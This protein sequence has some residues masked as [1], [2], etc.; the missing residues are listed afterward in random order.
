M[1]SGQRTGPGEQLCQRCMYFVCVVAT[2]VVNRVVRPVWSVD[3][4]D[5][6]GQ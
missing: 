4:Y 6:C 5:L 3:V 2:C 1:E